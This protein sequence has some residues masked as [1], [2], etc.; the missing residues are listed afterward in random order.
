MYGD[1]RNPLDMPHEVI[2]EILYYLSWAD[3]QQ[4]HTIKNKRLR[5]IT[6]SII[7]RCKFSN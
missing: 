3:L 5:A 1:K 4:V 2:E 6:K 7:D